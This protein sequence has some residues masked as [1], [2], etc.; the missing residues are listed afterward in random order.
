MGKISVRSEHR[1]KSKWAPLEAREKR[2]AI[3]D[4]NVIL[5]NFEMILNSILFVARKVRGRV[6]ALRRSGKQSEAALQRCAVGS[7]GPS[8]QNRRA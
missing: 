6:R 5:T 1:G 7:Q 2:Q 3:F 8:E 4:Q